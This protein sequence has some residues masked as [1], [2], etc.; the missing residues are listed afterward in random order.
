MTSLCCA[1]LCTSLQYFNGPSHH[2][3]LRSILFMGFGFAVSYFL[4]SYKVNYKQDTVPVT[5]ISHTVT[6]T[7]SKVEDNIGNV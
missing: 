5:L 2:C 6:K 7:S 4:Q 1:V 3:Q